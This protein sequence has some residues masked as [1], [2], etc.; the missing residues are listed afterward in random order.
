MLFTITYILFN[1]NERKWL[2]LPKGRGKQHHRRE[3]S[4]LQTLVVLLF[5]TLLFDGAAFLPILW[6]ELLFTSL[7]LCDDAWPSPSLGRG[8]V[9]PRAL[10]WC[11]FSGNQH[12]LEEWE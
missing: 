10:G 2:S 5:F 12:H 8:A 11:Y 3:K 1:S 6:V 9:T 7:Q 4:Q